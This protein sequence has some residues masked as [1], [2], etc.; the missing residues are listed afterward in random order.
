MLTSGRAG[1]TEL[2]L[3]LPTQTLKRHVGIFLTLVRSVQPWRQPYGE[4]AKP[5]HSF[6]RTVYPRRRSHLPDSRPGEVI[7]VVAGV[8]EGRMAKDNAPASELCGNR[9]RDRDSSDRP[10]H[11]DGREGLGL[12]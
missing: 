5:V 1:L 12:L 3:N 6:D 2:T 11:E 4:M 7:P 9:A 8:R 10:C